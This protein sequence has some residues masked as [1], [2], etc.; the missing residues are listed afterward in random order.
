[1]K[2]AEVAH[3]RAILQAQAAEPARRG[4]FGA[5]PNP[6]AGSAV[7]LARV[8]GA[9]VPAVSAAAGWTPR[10]APSGPPPRRGHSLFGRRPVEPEAE[11]VAEPLVLDQP[12]EPAARLR[13]RAVQDHHHSETPYHAEDLADPPSPAGPTP[14]II[15]G[16]S[17]AK[18]PGAQVRLLR[19]LGAVVEAERQGLEARLASAGIEPA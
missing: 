15:A 12:V 2:Q 4:L 7:T 13:L 16:W 3:Y 8:G 18:P 11:L 5:R 19:R 17:N 6:Q 1:M 10:L 14:G 9:M